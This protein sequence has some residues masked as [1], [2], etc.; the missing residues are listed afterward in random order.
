MRKVVLALL[1]AAVPWGLARGE[2]PA[3][4]KAPAPL[5]GIHWE[6]DFEA[7]MRRAAKEGRPVFVAVNALETEAA[8]NQLASRQ[9]RSKEWGTATRGFVSFVCNPTTHGQGEG[10]CT[11]YPGHTCAG[12]AAALGWFLKRFGQ[13]LISPQH[14]ILEPDGAVAYRKEYYERVVGPSLIENYLSK[15]APS[16]AYARAGVGRDARM[17][18]IGEAPLEEVDALAEAWLDG[19]DGLAAAAIVNVLDDC[20]D[21]QRRIELIAALRHTPPLQVPVLAMAA[22]ERVMYPA[23]E[24][25][26]TLR[27]ITTLFAADRQ[28]GVWAATRALT[29]LEDEKAR[30]AV[31]RAWAGVE[32]TAKAPEID[33][34]PMPERARAYEAL[35]LAG[36][37]R[38]RRTPPP[39]S[40]TG[41]RE[42]QVERA[43][44]KM[45]LTTPGDVN[46]KALLADPHPATLRRALLDA[47]P[48]EVRANED[49]VVRAMRESRYQRVS[50][51]AALA[52]LKARVADQE[53]SVSA[54]VV[55]GKSDLVEGPSTRRHAIAIL[56]EDPGQGDATW[57]AAIA[58]HMRGGGR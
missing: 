32:P 12:H 5:P 3:P 9:Y 40:W 30:D 49:G 35:L 14:V 55:A 53:P 39:A 7:G 51:A 4:R 31:L 43:R 29:R 15:L 26:E 34:L 38:A 56:G 8:N 33:D 41:G 48:E 18:A 13:D 23:D 11:R 22:E 45:G 17:K 25:H 44:R 36:D 28:T 58:R 42:A 27:W 2:E 1:L 37:R 24:A 10:A 20:F 57:R 52:L 6:A 54:L 46:L 21:A 50:L 47:T 16:I 19:H